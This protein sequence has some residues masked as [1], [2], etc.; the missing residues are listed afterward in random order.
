M[1]I[2]KQPPTS[3]APAGLF[4]GDAWWDVIYAGEEPSRARA[5]MVKF[6]PGARTAWHSHA[7]GQTLHIVE[8]AS[9]R[10]LARRCPV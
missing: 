10:K 3:K 7:M 5:N 6:A 4:T 1:E 9:S 2:L 8:S